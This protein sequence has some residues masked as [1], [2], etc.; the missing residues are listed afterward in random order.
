MLLS[1]LSVPSQL[2]RLPEPDP[3]ESN[4]RQAA[5]FEAFAVPV[6]VLLFVAISLEVA[7]HGSRVFGFAPGPHCCETQATEA[8]G[9][10]DISGQG[11]DWPCLGS[12]RETRWDTE[13]VRWLLCQLPTRS[14]PQAV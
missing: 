8:R 3:S 13:E 12:G 5:D 14:W 4:E 10:K 6:N 11:V 1:Q 9:C 7:G 2:S